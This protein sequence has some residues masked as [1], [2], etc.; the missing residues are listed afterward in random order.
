[1]AIWSFCFKSICGYWNCIFFH[2]FVP[3][4]NLNVHIEQDKNCR[5][6]D[7]TPTA[8]PFIVTVDT[9]AHGIGAT[10]SQSQLQEGGKFEER[11]IRGNPFG[12]H[13]IDFKYKKIERTGEFPS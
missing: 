7:F 3:S 8:K 11:I 2:L 13:I 9:S 10:L 1:M 6:A 4:S 5:I 12:C